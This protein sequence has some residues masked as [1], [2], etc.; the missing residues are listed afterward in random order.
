MQAAQRLRKGTGASMSAVVM[1]L[2]WAVSHA[3]CAATAQAPSSTSTAFPSHDALTSE[4][5][6]NTIPQ[7]E[8]FAVDVSTEHVPMIVL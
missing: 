4:P 3:S 6:Q 5:P 8:T 7:H 2:H 1:A